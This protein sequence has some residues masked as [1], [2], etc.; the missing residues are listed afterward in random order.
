MR[1]GEREVGCPA[2]RRLLL[3]AA[4]ARQGCRAAA[5]QGQAIAAARC[6]LFTSTNPNV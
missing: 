3:P 4:P 5:V 1:P 6:V 2:C